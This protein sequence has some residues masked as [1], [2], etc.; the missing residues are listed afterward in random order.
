[1]RVMFVDDEP[2]VL[3]G[4][5]RMLD[6]ADVDWE[7]ETAGGGAEA[8]EMLESDPV[9]VL[10]SDMMMPGMDGSQLLEQV[11]DRFPGV[12]RIIL[13]GQAT[14]ESVYRA[15]KPMHQ[16][17][18]KPCEADVLLETISRACALRATLNKVNAHDLLQGDLKLPS[19]PSLYQEIVAEMESE[20]GSVARVGEIIA[21]DVAMTAKILQIANSALFGARATITSPAQAATRLGLDTLKALVLSIQVFQSF[22]VSS[23]PGFQLEQLQ[24]HCLA[25]GQLA[26]KIAQSSDLDSDA[27]GEAFT[28]GLLHDTGKLV[29]AAN[30]PETFAK[31][32]KA[33]KTRP[34]QVRSIEQELIGLGHDEIG[35]YLL[36]LWGI[37]QGIVE[38]VAFHHHIED[39]GESSLSIPF[40]VYLANS[41]VRR[42]RGSLSDEKYQTMR[43]LAEKV[44]VADQLE[45][46][47]ELASLSEV[48]A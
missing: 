45:T 48:T 21:K 8:L 47:S 9:D 30:Q 10:V 23:I 14:R 32:L 40:V 4:I 34:D 17:L 24:H 29:L 19:L 46:W 44:G 13:S 12:V 39:F 42:S 36:A 1:M 38:A 11:A 18:S 33:A 37:P 5:T 15:V 25:V 22:D 31:V 27:V 20:H 6:C 16:Y 28:A 26:R 3:R 2:Q 35:G 7:I 41:L 43:E